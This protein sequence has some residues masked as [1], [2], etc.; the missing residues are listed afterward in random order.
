MWLGQGAGGVADRDRGA[1]RRACTSRAIASTV[2]TTFPSASTTDS[3]SVPAGDI[4][5]AFYISLDVMDEPGVLASVA[6]V[7]GAHERVDS[8]D[9]AVRRG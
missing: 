6:G 8:V 5:S 9:G 3:S 2:A 7:F 4:E 1:R